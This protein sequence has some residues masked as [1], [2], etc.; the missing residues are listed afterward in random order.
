MEKVLDLEEDREDEK[1]KDREEEKDMKE[2]MNILISKLNW[3]LK[4][5][6]FNFYKLERKTT[7][8]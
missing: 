8:G 5:K 1:K 7:E 4:K 6:N 2:K 3:T